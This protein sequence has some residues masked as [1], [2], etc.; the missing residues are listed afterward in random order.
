M[1][2]LGHRTKL[3]DILSSIPPSTIEEIALKSR[4][5]A[6]YIKEWLGAMVTGKIIEYD[7]INNKFWLSKEKAQY[8][9]RENI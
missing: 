5:N 1:L 3:F 9:T 8:L 2:S 4:L 6:R 7:P